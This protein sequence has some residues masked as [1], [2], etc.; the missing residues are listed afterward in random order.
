MSLIIESIIQR[1]K[2]T[3]V[4]LDGTTYH[5][6]PLPRDPRHLAEVL[7]Q[8]HAERF[9]SIREG[10]RLVS[11]VLES[12]E[13]D[14]VISEG[15]LR[16]STAHA[17]QFNLPDGSYITLGQLTEYAF[18]E[19]GYSV[20]E[21]N[22]LDDQAMHEHLDAGFEELR[23][24]AASEEGL[25][26]IRPVPTG[27]K[28][29][30]AHIQPLSKEDQKPAP[31]DDDGKSAEEELAD[32]LKVEQKR[33]DDEEAERK[34]REILD[35]SNAG[36]SDISGA[37]TD[38]GADAGAGTGTDNGTQEE[39]KQPGVQSALVENADNPGSDEG[40]ASVADNVDPERQALIEAYT[41]KMGRKPHHKLSNDRI[42]AVLAESEE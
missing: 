1:E 9:L 2:G 22:N 10:F 13:Q 25:H 30:A 14:V 21:W 3:V 23:I 26:T 33:L 7:I 31:E 6:K 8:A 12:T 35:K 15:D 27:P 20:D 38:A 18:R 41:A 37:G 34:A 4:E 36:G 28:M 40:K 32:K 16:T 39:A 17:A 5:F 42:K 24:E 29:D 11:G 19:S